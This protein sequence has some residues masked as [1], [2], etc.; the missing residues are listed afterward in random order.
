MPKTP[1]AEPRCSAFAEV[2][3]R[4]KAHATERNRETHTP[5]HRHTPATSRVYSSK[6]WRVLRLR[7][8][9]RYPLCAECGALAT[10]VDHVT[11]IEEGGQPWAPANLQSL[12]ATCHGR[13]TAGEVRAREYA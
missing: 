7:T 12:C 4:C 9:R 2:R 5:R 13:K 1:C 8:L 11:P 3:G 10:E 6:R